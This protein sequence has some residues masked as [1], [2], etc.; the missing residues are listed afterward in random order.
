MKRNRADQAP[1]CLEYLVRCTIRFV[2]EELGEQHVIC[3]AVAHLFFRSLWERVIV[4]GVIK[5][6]LVSPVKFH[7]RS[8]RMVRCLR[9]DI[10]R[11]YLITKRTHLLGNLLP[12]CN[13]IKLA[14]RSGQKI[15]RHYQ[16][17]ITAL[18]TFSCNPIA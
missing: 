6:V 16:R 12:E 18:L 3:A 2:E 13:H 7:P 4:L 11:N 1:K 5:F 15:Q 9:N 8:S 10:T 17:T 14:L